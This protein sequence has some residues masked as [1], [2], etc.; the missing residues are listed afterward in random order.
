MNGADK[1]ALKERIE[2]A[3]SNILSDRHEC[4]VTVRFKKTKG[5]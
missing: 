1:I 2:K 5:D 3:L 4:K